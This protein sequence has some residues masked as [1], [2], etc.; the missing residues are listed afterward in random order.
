MSHVVEQDKGVISVIVLSSPEPK[1]SHHQYEK[2]CCIL[3]F[4]FIHLMEK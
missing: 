1:E 4:L 3:S 2:M